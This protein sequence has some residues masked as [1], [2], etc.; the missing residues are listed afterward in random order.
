MFSDKYVKG[1]IASKL[2]GVHQRTLY[3]WEKKGKI[4]TIRTP[5]GMRLYNVEKFIKDTCEPKNNEC[6]DNFKKLDKMNGKVNISYARVSSISQKDDLQRQIKLIKKKYPT[7][8]IIKDIG[9][10]MNFNKRGLRKIIKLAISG[11]IN[12]LVIAYKDRLTRIGYD[13][14]ENLIKEYSNGKII[15]LNKKE[16]MSSEE[17]LVYDVLQI[18]NIYVA[19]MNG[20][21]K[22]KKKTK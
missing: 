19:K 7:H 9:S 16:K 12:E 5:G 17:E 18:M 2:I 1:S 14:I 10:G 21:R 3:Q 8:I 22:Y 13:L 20:M 15:I 6:I 11:K 4:K